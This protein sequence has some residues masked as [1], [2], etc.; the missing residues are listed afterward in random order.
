MIGVVCLLPMPGEGVSRLVG[1]LLVLPG[2]FGAIASEINRLLLLAQD[3]L[4]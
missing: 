4:I 2:Q 3:F 1:R